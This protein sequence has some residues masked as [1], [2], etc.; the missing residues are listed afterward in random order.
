MISESPQMLLEEEKE[1]NNH[2]SAA[3]KEVLLSSSSASSTGKFMT[4]HHLYMVINLSLLLCFVELLMQ[5]Q[6]W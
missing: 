1:D 4:V 6:C 3:S 2:N 5:L